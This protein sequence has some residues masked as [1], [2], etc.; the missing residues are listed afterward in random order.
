M[1]T[2]NILYFVKYP[3][4]G[5][6]KTRL[7]KT[8][9]DEE[10]TRV[11]RNLV[12][13]NLKA[14][15][16]L[17]SSG[18]DITITFDPPDAAEKMKQWLSDDYDYLPQS[19]DGLGER[20]TKAFGNLFERKVRR[21][22]AVGSDTLG[23]EANLILK[24]C[25]SLEHFD[26]VLGPAEDGGYYLIGLSQPEPI[27]FQDIPWSTS[28]VFDSTLNRIKQKG[29]SFYVLPELQDLDDIE[30]LKRARSFLFD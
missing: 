2:G 7:A 22:L 5:K 3:E 25:D 11:Y 16:P 27:L 12:E 1:A 28:A 24:A 9:G 18:I 13:T 21:V 4:P 26:V 17:I 30:D 19:G 8:L 6:V 14:I 20:L 10:A 23:L 29:L 15:R